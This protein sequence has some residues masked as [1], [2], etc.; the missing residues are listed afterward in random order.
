MQYVMKKEYQIY[1]PFIMHKML[2]LIISTAICHF[3]AAA[4][5]CWNSF[6]GKKRQSTWSAGLALEQEKLY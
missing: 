4:F 5:P 1:S 6:P 2:Y 3:A